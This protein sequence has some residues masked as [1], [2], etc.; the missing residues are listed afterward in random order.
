MLINIYLPDSGEVV[1]RGSR[2]NQAFRDKVGYLPEE[3]GLYHRMKVLD[4]ILF[5]AELKGLRAREAMPRAM[6]LLER[7]D[8]LGRKNARVEDLSRG[9]QQKVQFIISIMADPDFI[10]LDEPFS[11][12][13]AMN[14]QTLTEVILG[15]KNRGKVIIFSTHLMEFAEKL[16]DYIAII[17]QGH[18]A[19]K[20]N[21]AE[22]K[23]EYGQK[24]VSLRYEGDISF[25]RDH[26]FVQSMED[27]GKATRIQ[28]R[29]IRQKQDLLRLLI[30]QNIAIK[31]F[32]AH[33]IS[34]HDIFMAIAGDGESQTPANRNM[35]RV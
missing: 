25:L 5:F 8:L 30:E 29:E 20:G 31:R 17:D 15:L 32:D 33:D 22:I 26:E 35:T 18:L 16:C 24:N 34:L 21:L 11:G 10:I 28:V 27:F 19:L 4:T 1:F 9:N 2:V 3:R 6:E 14:T 23:K 7:F 13:D 12:L